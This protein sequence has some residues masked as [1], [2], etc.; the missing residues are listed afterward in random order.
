[1][2]LFILHDPHTNGS[3]PRKEPPCMN[4]STCDMSDRRTSASASYSCA[5]PRHQHDRTPAPSHHG[6][7]A[8]SPP[9]SN[10]TNHQIGDRGCPPVHSRST[11]TSLR[12]DKSHAACTR[13]PTSNRPLRSLCCP[14]VQTGAAPP[15]PD[16][17]PVVGTY[18]E[19]LFT[20]VAPWPWP[21]TF[22]AA[23][24]S[25]PLGQHCCSLMFPPLETNW[26]GETA[27][28]IQIATIRCLKEVI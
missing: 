25:H 19:A 6:N 24:P 20:I 18:V 16:S 13:P 3:E 8:P 26:G 23:S 5:P 9:S 22:D 15:F 11:T 12:C 17:S 21:Q 1:L 2:P 28:A 14:H 4:L 10:H 7:A 27:Q